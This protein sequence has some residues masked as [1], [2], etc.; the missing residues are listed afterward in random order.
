MCFA[1]VNRKGV[2]RERVTLFTAILK[3]LHT[4][5]RQT[6]HV[7]I[8]LMRPEW[9]NEAGGCRN[10]KPRRDAHNFQMWTVY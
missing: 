2:S 10:L 4:G 1:G 8:V 6:N 5:R 9:G 3:A 7:A